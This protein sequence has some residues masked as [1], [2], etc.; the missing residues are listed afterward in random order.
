MEIANGFITALNAYGPTVAI[1]A[2]LL[3]INAVFVWRDVRRED[4]YLQRIVDLETKVETVVLPIVIRYEVLANDCKKAI[5]Q[6]TRAF[7]QLIGK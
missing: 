5:E 3:V 1:V 6:C 4:K 2:A 7:E